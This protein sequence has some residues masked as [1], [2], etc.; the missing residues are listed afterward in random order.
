MVAKPGMNAARSREGQRQELWDMWAVLTNTVR[1]YVRQQSALIF[2]SLQ[3][4]VGGQIMSDT[5]KSAKLKDFDEELYE[6]CLQLMN[7]YR[8]FTAEYENRQ[9]DITS[10]AA[11]NILEGIYLVI[12]AQLKQFEDGNANGLPEE[13]PNP[14]TEE[15]RIICEKGTSYTSQ[16]IDADA[17]RFTAPELLEKWVLA[18]LLVGSDLAFDCL[19]NHARDFCFDAAYAYYKEGLRLCLA[20]LNDL[21]ERKVVRYYTELMESERDV[22]NS[23]I[24]IQVTALEETLEEDSPDKTTVQQILSPLGEGYQRFNRAATRLE[25]LLH[26]QQPSDYP[27]Q[28]YDIFGIATENHIK[29][30]YTGGQPAY[31]LAEHLS[32]FYEALDKETD[33]LHDQMRHRFNKAAYDLKRQLSGETMLA[34]AIIGL[35]QKAW[36]GLPDISVFPDEPSMTR[37]ILAGVAETIGIKIES[38]RESVDIFN[39]TGAAMITAF[40]SAKKDMTTEEKQKAYQTV[41][42]GWEMTMTQVPRPHISEFFDN[43]LEEDSLTAAHAHNEKLIEEYTVKIDKTL[44]NFKKETLLY[45]ICTYEEILTHSVSQLYDTGIEAVDEAVVLMSKTFRDLETLLKKNNIQVIRPLPHEPFN[46]REHEVIVAEEQ[47]GFTKGEII[48]PVNSGY[49]Q[50]GQVILRANVIAAK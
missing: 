6:N 14:I 21:H 36:N 13:K 23:L 38:L 20:G 48:K 16:H 7:S 39:E 43:C 26:D 19:F 3:Q 11:Q 34:E 50:N 44:L 35:F 37:D 42:D 46:G 2:A 27:Y 12:S 32:A 45:E 24:T 31:V 49:K 47:E 5:A 15:K 30:C 18:V 33:A 8:E 29:S 25:E 17:K 10:P 40:T 9:N 4:S 22:L 1:S 41:R 28:P